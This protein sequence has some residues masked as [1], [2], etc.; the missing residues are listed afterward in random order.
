LLWSDRNESGHEGLVR[1]GQRNI[2]RNGFQIAGYRPGEA[3]AIWNLQ[4]LR[5]LPLKVTEKAMPQH[6]TRARLSRV[7]FG[8]LA[9]MIAFSAALFSAAHHFAGQLTKTA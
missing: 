9:A 2:T 8:A 4:R 5:R 1:D 3:V 7:V 6:L